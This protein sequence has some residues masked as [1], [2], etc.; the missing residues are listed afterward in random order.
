M[1]KILLKI[2]TCVILV[3]SI[4]SVMASTLN[5]N[6]DP[7]VKMPQLQLD[8]RQLQTKLQ[9]LQSM[10]SLKVQQESK[11]YLTIGKLFIA[12]NKYNSSR[13][14][15]KIVGNYAYI[16]NNHES[17]NVV[18]IAD[19]TKPQLILSIKIKD[20]RNLAVIG[21]LVCVAQGE[22][23]VA[24][25]DLKQRKMCQLKIGWSH[26]IVINGDYAYVTSG[27]KGVRTININQKSERYLQI[28]KLDNINSY[29]VNIAIIANCAYV[30]DTYGKIMEIDLDIDNPSNSREREKGVLAATDKCIYTVF[31]QDLRCMVCKHVSHIEQMN[32]DYNSYIFGCGYHDDPMKEP[33]A[34]LP[35]CEDHIAVT[36]DFIYAVGEYV[37]NKI[38][39]ISIKDKNK[40]KQIGV[41]TTDYSILAIAVDSKEQFIYVLDKNGE[42]HI[43]CPIIIAEQLL[44]EYQ[45]KLGIF[46]TDIK[47]EHDVMVLQHQC[48]N[49]E[50][51]GTLAHVCD[52]LNDATELGQE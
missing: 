26:D 32:D 45:D 29:A 3:F 20:V 8:W 31:R 48:L 15:I 6:F 24:I 44:R 39:I 34:T 1:N 36:K 11:K 27:E 18:D 49:K 51:H 10:S 19:P 42:L 21:D 37:N 43:I 14:L 23:G 47:Q 40:P 22:Y 52:A 12:K 17:L 50:L 13:G 9:S 41:L 4:S 35:I 46:K 5:L 16:V 7:H 28:K 33:M 25:I 30:R 2:Y 38:K